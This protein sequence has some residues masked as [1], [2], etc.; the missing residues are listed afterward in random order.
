MRRFWLVGGLALALAEACDSGAGLTTPGGPNAVPTSSSGGSSS[1][2]GTAGDD[3]GGGLPK[4]DP[5]GWGD[6]KTVRRPGL[7]RLEQLNVRR[8]FDTKCDSGTCSADEHGEQLRRH[9]LEHPVALQPVGLRGVVL[10]RLPEE[11]VGEGAA[12]VVHAVE[13]TQRR[14]GRCTPWRPPS[15]S[16]NACRACSRRDCAGSKRATARSCFGVPA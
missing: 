16:L 4:P 11:A 3:D 9:R 15:R 7:L 2:S 5:E 13:P 14:P 6:P 1:S 8:F 12:R 10:G